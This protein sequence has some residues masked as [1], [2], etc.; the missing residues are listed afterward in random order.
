[1]TQLPD[2]LKSFQTQAEES[3]AK[4]LVRDI[5]F[6]DGTY[7]VQVLDEVSKEAV[8][9]FLQLDS[10][11]G[12]KDCFCSCETGEDI[13]YC[14][15][16]AAAFLRIYNNQP[17]PLH[18]RFEQSLWNKLCR[19][20]ADR[21]GDKRS[22]LI[23]EESGHYS[24]TS[25][26][27][28]KVFFVKAKSPAAKH[29]LKEII[30]ERP[31]E[32]EETSLKFSNLPPEE[33][34]LWREG[35]PSDQLRYELS[36][37]NDFAHWMMMMQDEGVPYEISFDYSSKQDLPNHITISFPELQIGFYISE[38][39]LPLIIPGLATVKSP[40]AVHQASQNTIK[41]IAYDKAS[42]SLIIIPKEEEEERQIHKASSGKKQKA[43]SGYKLEGWQ[44][45]AGDG[46]YAR[47]QH[48]L[49]SNRTLT[50]RQISEALNDHFPIIQML[51]EGASLDSEP[52]PLSY[53]I[54]FDPDWNLHIIAYA[55]T[56]GDL[57]GPYAGYFGDWVYLEDDGFYHITEPHFDDVE[58]VIPCSEV[59][60][61]VR[62]ER[63]W[64]NTQEEGF[65]TH[66]ASVEA[67]LSYRLSP[68]GRLTFTRLISAK[69]KDI[70]S[71][72]FGAWIY[73]VG[74]G[75]YSKVSSYT[76][77]QLRPDLSIN[78]D[79]IPL[80]IRM[81]RDE[82][83]LVSN[84]FSETCPVAKMSLNIS[85]I[86]D[87]VN[88][89][90]E[91]EIKSNYADKEIRFFDDFVYV[92]G[93]GFHDLPIDGR[94]PEKFR[95][96]TEVQPDA[97]PMFL[98]YEIDALKPFT[99]KID[100]SL[101]KP[102]QIDLIAQ[103]ITKTEEGLYALKLAYQTERGVVPLNTLWTAIKK[104]KKLFLFSQAGLFDLADENFRW[105]RLLSK[106]RIDKRTNILLVSTLELIRLHSLEGMEVEAKAD[107][108]S[109]KLLD[110]LTHFTIP[111]EPDLSGLK[112]ELR[113]YQKLGVDWLWFLYHHNLSGLLCD[114][115]GLGKTHQTMALLAAIL[116]S[117]KASRT[118]TGQETGPHFLIVCPTSVIFHWQEKLQDF[119]PG[120]RVCT[121]YGSNRSLDEFHHQYDVLLTSYGIW[122]IE[123]ELLST[124]A[125]DVAIFDEIQIAKNHHS[126]VHL[127]LLSVQ[128]KMRIGLTGTPIENHLRELKSLFDLILPTYMPGDH[129]YR[130]MFVKPIEKEGC[131]EKRALLQRF[132][133]PFVLRRKKETVLLDLP[134][135]TE[136]ISHCIL[137]SEQQMLY[138][139]ALLRS[140][141]ALL[142]QLQDEGSNIPYIHVFALLSSLKQICNH[143]AVYL[144][145]PSEYKKYS[146]G[147]WDLFVELLN[148]ARESQQKIVVFSQYLAMLDIFEEYLNELGM[149]FATIRGATTN[150]GEQVQRFNKDPNC[151]VFLGSLQAAGLGVDLTAGSVVIHYDR[152]WNAARENQA[153]DRV[154]RI[155]QTRGVQVF[156]L[157][158]KGTFEERIDE[159]IAKKGQLMEEVVGIDDHRFLKKFTREELI[160]LLTLTSSTGDE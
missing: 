8:W 72:D 107:P 31:K 58:T 43:G 76:G 56:P 88:V 7:Q 35:R 117:R 2:N 132:I 115:M 97:L 77:L 66:L 83:Q 124:V 120:V 90:P 131:K 119:L 127:S 100:P 15:H 49:L 84:F 122:R 34:I 140:R 46:F 147:K 60:D 71:K 50:G 75:F 134:E 89:T 36:F 157:V 39:N 96:A 45:F 44:Y 20:Y 102:N 112:S 92:E 29:H 144:K 78:A 18:Q 48:Q 135:K 17:W 32:T 94:I 146:S 12:I 158:T 121:F 105:I 111:A 81:N 74:K 93:E 57:S 160:Q 62:R 16:I 23:K 42:K 152:W 63:A 70:Q 99:A 104:K 24:H 142:Q 9:A 101:I 73:I 47:D 19:I 51:L 11:G 109:H 141:Q 54:T 98:T 25:V 22:L 28:K 40:L 116:N 159:L 95:H 27:G 37:W 118:T 85:L 21:L 4:G 114:D 87:T 151:E 128:T 103:H 156:K 108:D 41:Q 149:G 136:E 145:T 3:I 52:I 125:F 110:E 126:R 137:S 91:Y 153:T 138:N 123:N 59:S 113:P 150:R 133:K 53:S 86:D 13:S 143:P 130:E 155:G 65:N 38:A 10:R 82:L 67:L 79:Q 26:G 106:D 148:E 69:E 5:E 6:S 154:H 139:A 1:M 14:R 61:F 129:D 68:E 55:F 33:L 80:F 64:L 30:E